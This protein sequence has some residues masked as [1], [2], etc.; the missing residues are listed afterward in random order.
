MQSNPYLLAAITGFVGIVG[1][2]LSRRPT[3]IDR[4]SASFSRLESIVQTLQEE[5]KSSK[6][7][8]GRLHRDLVASEERSRQLHTDL[9]STKA[10]LSIVEGLLREAISKLDKAEI[11]TGEL[12]KSYEQT[13]SR[14]A[15]SGTQ[16]S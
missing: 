13:Q 7:D 8:A 12:K 6:E 3:S 14:Q 4:D 16:N 11:D 2:W 1:G 10:Q 9:L 15:R 5:M